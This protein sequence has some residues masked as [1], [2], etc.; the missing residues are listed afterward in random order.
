MCHITK[1]MLFENLEQRKHTKIKIKIKFDT[2]HKKMKKFARGRGGRWE[3]W[4]VG[5]GRVGGVIMALCALWLVK[6]F[7][8]VENFVSECLNFN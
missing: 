7:W 8:L 1:L 3:G 6:T 5:G 2:F 4:E